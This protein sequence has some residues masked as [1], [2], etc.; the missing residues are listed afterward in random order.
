MIGWSEI[1]YLGWHYDIWIC[2]DCVKSIKKLYVCLRVHICGC[3]LKD[4]LDNLELL[5]SLSAACFESDDVV[6]V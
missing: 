3:F 4:C 1:L 6:T 5:E 2:C